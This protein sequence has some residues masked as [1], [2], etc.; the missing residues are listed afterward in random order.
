MLNQKIF[1]LGVLFDF[2]FFVILNV[3]MLIE[4]GNKKIFKQTNLMVEILAKGTF[5]KITLHSKKI[6]VYLD[7]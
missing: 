2:G 7:R 1:L 5:Y 4:K 6:T 3:I